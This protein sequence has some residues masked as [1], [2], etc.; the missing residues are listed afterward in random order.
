M[1]HVDTKVAGTL[2]ILVG[3]LSLLIVPIMLLNMFGGIVSGVWLL[4]LGKWWALGYGAGLLLASTFGLSLALLPS[5]LLM[6]PAVYLASKGYTWIAFP[7][8]LLGTLWTYTVMMVWCVWVLNLY[9]QYADTGSFYPLLVWSYGTATGP[10]TYMASKE[11]NPGS[12]IAAVAAQVGYI[13]MMIMVSF[14][15]VT[16]LD[17]AIAFGAVMLGALVL[18]SALAMR[19]MASE[20]GPDPAAHG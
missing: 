18:Q 9:M 10:W 13:V 14:Y 7:F 19:T 8:A 6:T 5:V 20:A 16:L 4:I 11:D 2:G 3:S 15:P 1:R 17:V 12:T